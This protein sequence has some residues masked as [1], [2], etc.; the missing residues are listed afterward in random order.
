[1]IAVS[2][3]EKDFR[4]FAAFDVFIR[5]RRW[6]PF[7][8][9]AGILTA[10]ALFCFLVPTQGNGALL[11]T[12]LLIVGLVLPAVFLRRFFAAVGVQAKKL[13]FG[14]G[15]LVYTLDLSPEAF[16][17]RPAGSGAERTYDWA[18]MFG[19]WRGRTATY[20]YVTKTE[21]FLLPDRFA[22]NRD[23]IWRLLSAALPPD[24]LHGT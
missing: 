7:A 16:T 4:S 5:L 14:D 11:G 17:V 20:L 9:F 24:K 19:V 8:G 6:I 12:V 21:V 1:M 22:P 2:I 3:S 15:R 10:S 18:D 23:A 13:K